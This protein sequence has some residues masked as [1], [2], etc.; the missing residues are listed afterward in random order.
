MAGRRPAGGGKPGRIPEPE[1]LVIGR[2][3]GPWGVKGE[4]KVQPVTEFPERFAEGQKVYLNGQ[5]LA[6]ERSFW[7]KGR[8]VLKLAGV[9][10]YE[11]AEK[12][13][14]RF[15]E[16]RRGELPSLE[17]GRYYHYQ[18][19]GL[20]VWT[21]GGEMVGHIQD[22]MSTPGNDVYVVGNGRQVLIPAVEDV[23]VEVDLKAGR[24]MVKPIEGLL[25]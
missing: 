12:V 5:P 21:T 7:H 23:V 1:F 24:V 10:S 16:V 22:V 18:M 20:E 17:E 19:I 15:L 25:E 6:V 3:L 11:A 2:I 14:G 8:V 13:R 4:V 9:D